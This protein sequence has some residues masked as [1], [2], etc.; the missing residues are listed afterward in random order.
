[1]PAPAIGRR[2]RPP[3]PVPR[4]D[5]THPLSAGLR[6]LWLPGVTQDL[7]DTAAWTETSVGFTAG[8]YGQSRE[9]G[10][11]GTPKIIR[12]S[13]PMAQ[14]G[15]LMVVQKVVG[16]PATNGCGVGNS[17]NDTTNRWGVHLPYGD[18]TIYFDVTNTTTGRL[19]YA[20]WAWG[21][22]D[23]FVFTNGNIGGQ[24][25]WGNGLRLA[26]DPTIAPSNGAS[27]TWGI[28]QHAAVTNSNAQQVAIVAGWTRE[29]LP[30]DVGTLYANPFCMLR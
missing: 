19:T 22:W 8:P 20:G 12:Q 14:V 5:W 25:I 9:V 6:T 29:L 11:G 30:N 28:G 16:T 24:S 4:V 26:N 15:S 13:H 27:G 23:V 18:S 1:M 2:F 7:V 10:S 21:N 3:T 17:L